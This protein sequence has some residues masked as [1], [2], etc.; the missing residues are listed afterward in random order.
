MQARYDEARGKWDSLQRGVQSLEGY[1]QGVSRDSLTMAREAPEPALKKGELAPDAL[2]R[3]RG[4]IE[5]LHLDLKM[6][7]AAPFPSSVVK[8]RM[9]AQIQALAASGEP[10]VMAAIEGGGQIEFRRAFFIPQLV[11]G[12]D[13]KVAGSVDFGAQIDTAG[14]VAWLHKDALIAALEREIDANADDASALD[15]STRKKKSERAK[16]EIL[17]AEREEEALVEICH[18]HG[19]MVP[20][21]DHA[22]PRA[23]LGVNGPEPKDSFR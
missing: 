2:A 20:R 3:T 7:E 14:L 5:E 6:I 13:G 10:D 11:K 18:A 21:R 15:N 16:A 23:V 17:A 1:L 4:K 12:T 8:S 22:D 19:H 9:R